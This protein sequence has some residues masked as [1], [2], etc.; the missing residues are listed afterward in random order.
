MSSTIIVRSGWD[1]VRYAMIFE[2]FLVIAVGA[3]LALVAEQSLLESAGLALV[4]SL[5]AMLAS[6][7]YNELYDRMDVHYGRIPTERSWRGRVLHAVGFESFLVLVSLPV[8]MWW[9]DWSWWQALAFDVVA[10]AGVIVYTFLFT[11]AY[12][13]VFPVVQ[14]AGTAPVS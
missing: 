12:D 14:R 11:L 1:R 9:L 2:F 8:I 7:I 3:A 10:M 4:L 6:V 13:R 5:I